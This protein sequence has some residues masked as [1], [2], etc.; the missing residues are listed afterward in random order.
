M[1]FRVEKSFDRDVG[2]IDDKKLLRK[3]QALISEIGRTENISEITNTKKMEGCGSFYRVKIGDYRLGME[4][5]PE[6]EIV[7]IRF[8]HRK[9]VYRYFPKRK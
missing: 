6:N 7:L 9:E 3:V 5:T 2:K 8:L 1:K 4:L